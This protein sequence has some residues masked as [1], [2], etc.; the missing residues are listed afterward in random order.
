ML[1][2]DVHNVFKPSHGPDAIIFTILVQ[3]YRVLVPQP[4]KV[5]PM[6]ILLKQGGVDYV[7]SLEW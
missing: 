2:V 3:V 5:G 4:S 1:F 6:N 7:N